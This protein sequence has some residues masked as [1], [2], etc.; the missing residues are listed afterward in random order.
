[1]G[2]LISK[3]S[4]DMDTGDEQVKAE[5]QQESQENSIMQAVLEQLARPKKIN[6]LRDARGRAISLTQE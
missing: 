3:H 2:D 6:V 1:M 5:P 4:L